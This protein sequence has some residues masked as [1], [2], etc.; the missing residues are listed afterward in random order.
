MGS[1]PVQWSRRIRS[2]RRGR[3]SGQRL[4][5]LPPPLVR[6]LHSDD[7]A[8]VHYQPPPTDRINHG[9]MHGLSVISD[10]CPFVRLCVR[11]FV[12][13]SA[14]SP[15]RFLNPTTPHHDA[16]PKVGIPPGSLGIV[17]V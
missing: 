12:H 5:N 10:L 11:R 9:R 13:L 2:A 1:R 16:E 17:K 8:P 7:A 4:T 14:N 3:W 6:Q 15:C